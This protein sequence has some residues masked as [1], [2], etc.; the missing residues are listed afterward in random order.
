MRPL[1]YSPHLLHS[2]FARRHSDLGYSRSWNI[3]PAA[4]CRLHRSRFA[5]P[6]QTRPSSENR[7]E[8]PVKS[9]AVSTPN[10]S[11]SEGH[12][13]RAHFAC[14]LRSMWTISMPSRITRA[15]AMKAEHRS[16][17]PF[18]GPLILLNPVVEIGN[19]SDANGVQATPC[20]AVSGPTFATCQR[21]F[22]CRGSSG[23]A[24]LVRLRAHL[25]EPPD[26]RTVSTSSPRW[27]HRTTPWSRS[28]L[29]PARPRWFVLKRGPAVDPRRPGSGRCGGL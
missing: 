20:R 3:A 21:V 14:C 19:L 5:D 10:G 8:W 6:S 9:H 24:V 26:M 11:A 2:G 15:L 7:A 23:V 18:D 22:R 13:L 28:R 25:P 1:D 29:P 17:P 12:R 27:R 4:P 16:D